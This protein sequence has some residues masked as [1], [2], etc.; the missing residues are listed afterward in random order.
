[1]NQHEHGPARRAQLLAGPGSRAVRRSL[2]AL[3]L[4]G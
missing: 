1:M 4:L 3:W 2:Y